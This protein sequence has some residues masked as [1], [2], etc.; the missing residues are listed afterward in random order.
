MTRAQKQKCNLNIARRKLHYNCVGAASEQVH[1]RYTMQI[2]GTDFGDGG[3]KKRF[4][5]ET[6]ERVYEPASQRDGVHW[7][8]RNGNPIECMLV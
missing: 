7:G 1:N 3:K 4:G 8:G 6:N 5:N 2:L